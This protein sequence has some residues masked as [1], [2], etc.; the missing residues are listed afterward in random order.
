MGS[1][2]GPST[3]TKKSVHEIPDLNFP[4]EETPSKDVCAHICAR[5]LKGLAPQ[6]GN[7]IE[8]ELPSDELHDEM[9]INY[10]NTGESMNQATVNVDISIAKKIAS[11]IDLD[12][13]PNML[14]DCKKRS[15]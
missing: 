8:Q 15:Y 9:V 3:S 4:I 11:T 12:P 7:L 10:I 1:Q 2:L 14:T 5:I 6:K 13:E